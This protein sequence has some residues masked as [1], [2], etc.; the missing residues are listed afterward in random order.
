MRGR[1]KYGISVTPP[2]PVIARIAIARM[3]H[4]EGPSPLK[5]QVT[6]TESPLSRC[7]AKVNPSQPPDQPKQANRLLR[8]H[9]LLTA[10]DRRTPLFAGAYCTVI[11][12]H[13]AAG[14]DR[15]VAPYS[16]STT[17]SQRYQADAECPACGLACSTS[18]A[19]RPSAASP[20]AT[21][22]RAASRAQARRRYWRGD[23]GMISASALNQQVRPDVRS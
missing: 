10:V 13:A 23:Q 1:G 3:L 17:H 9:F 4:A 18:P 20:T 7:W 6:A 12:R 5:S 16:K 22:V 19:P 11:A 21:A 14:G 8:G 15:A 2:S